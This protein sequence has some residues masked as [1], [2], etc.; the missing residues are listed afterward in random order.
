MCCH[1]DKTWPVPGGRTIIAPGPATGLPKCKASQ[2]PSGSCCK[3]SSSG[4]KLPEGGHGPV[5]GSRT[6]DTDRLDI[7]SDPPQYFPSAKLL[8]GHSGMS[9]SNAT[10]CPKQW[11]LSWSSYS[12][13]HHIFSDESYPHYNTRFNITSRLDLSWAGTQPSFQMSHT[14]T[15]I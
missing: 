14:N 8:G 9:A 3:Q 12:R 1:R 15:T 13:V 2:G 10:W 6:H 7:A 11:D 5:P 4:A